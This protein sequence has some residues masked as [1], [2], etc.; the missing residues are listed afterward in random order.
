[1]P[2]QLR[3]VVGKPSQGAPL[4][5]LQPRLPATTTCPPTAVDPSVQLSVRPSVPSKPPPP[6]VHPGAREHSRRCAGRRIESSSILSAR[7]TGT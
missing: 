7:G 2:K 1:M 5:G 6:P 3:E 4:P